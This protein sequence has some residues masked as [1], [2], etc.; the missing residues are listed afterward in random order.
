M[1]LSRPLSR[2]DFLRLTPAAVLS[3]SLALPST[4]AGRSARAQT[5]ARMV[6]RSIPSSGEHLP[7]VGCGT[8][9]TFDVGPSEAE[10]LPLE[11]V[12]AALFDAGGSVIDSSPMYGRSEGVV[13]D[14]LAA[15]RKRDK[16]FLAT[17]VWTSGREAG[18]AQMNQSFERFHTDKIDLMQIHNLL[19]WQTHLPTMRDWKEQ[20]RIR[21]IGVTHYSDSAH[22]ALLAVLQKK[23]V[24]FVQ[25]NYA[26]DDRNAEKALLPFARDNRI[27]VIVN[28][29]FG[30]GG[31]L[32]KLAGRPLPDWAKEIA[33][34]SWPQILLKFVLANPAVTCVI[35]GTSKPEH[36]RDNALAGFGV[37]PDAAMLKRMIAELGA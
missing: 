13:G 12:L 17:K 6:S 37:P 21:Y 33:C 28:L 11:G 27:A 24:D 16:A 7:I 29:P 5:G 18:I 23:Q 1:G 22:E 15:T 9:Q 30:G 2:A 32:R 26:I 34:T 31:L 20:G 19:D 8:W 36:M 3:S 25:V 4:L 35:P 10:R 14:I